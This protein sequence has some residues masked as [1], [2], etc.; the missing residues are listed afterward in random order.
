[1][2]ST[3]QDHSAFLS[4]FRDVKCNT[5]FGDPRGVYEGDIVVKITYD[6]GEYELIRSLGRGFYSFDQEQFNDLIEKYSR[7]TAQKQLLGESFAS[8]P[9]SDVSEWVDLSNEEILAVIEKI[10]SDKYEAYP[11]THT[12]PIAATLYKDGE[13]I[14]IDANDP[15]LIRLTNFFNNCVYYSK[16]GYIQSLLPLEDIKQ[17]TTAPFR[18]ELKYVPYGDTFPGPYIRC[19]TMCDTIIITNPYSGFTLIAHD[20]PGYEDLEQEYPFC[21][22]GFYPLYNDYA[23]LDLFGF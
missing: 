5:F 16:C 11:N 20:L 7:E 14:Y 18:L 9:F 10:P 19:T 23:W 13:I 1:M 21:A 15:R 6:N 12:V 4:D 3:V 2:I 8:E 22:C 17:V